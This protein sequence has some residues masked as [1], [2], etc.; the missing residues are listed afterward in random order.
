MEDGAATV[1]VWERTKVGW[2][3]AFGVF[4]VATAVV[5]VVDD[6]T[7]DLHR[8][9]ALMLLAGMCAAYV[10]VGS[11]ALHAAANTPRSWAYLGI[12]GPVAVAMFALT[13]VASVMLF[14]LYPQIW[15]MLPAR[16]ASWVTAAVTVGVGAVVAVGG[17]LGIA[18]ISF[19]VGL[20]G[21][22]VLG[23]W[24]SK[25]IEQSGERA[26]V[27]AE[28]AATRT[29]LAAVSHEAGVLAERER[30]AGDLHDTLAQGATSVL[31]L[32][33]AAR[34][35]LHRDLAESERHLDLAEQTTRENLAELRTLVA[36]LTPPALDGVSLPAAL[37]RL[38]DRLR[39]ESGMAVTMAVTGTHRELPVAC[40][41]TLLRVTQESLSNVRRHSGATTVTVD[42]AFGDDDVT[43]R[44]ADDG[45]GFDPDHR[46]TGF[47]LDG[48]HERVHRVAGDL[49]VRAAPGDGVTVL[50]RLTDREAR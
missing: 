30:L 41:V 21:A 22:P 3:V 40:E 37:A 42:L 19:A 15:S 9:I 25:I 47:G 32:L 18:A 50:V 29:E 2:H 14:V 31:L 23:L 43:L 5:L 6:T 45:R 17:E 36:E 10:C 44:I 16:R 13:P 8:W 33:G 34:A 12:A 28:L 24:I 49:T 35:A 39:A 20:V 26:R 46:P 11:R 38:T 48:L 7:P 4:V 27:L 1:D